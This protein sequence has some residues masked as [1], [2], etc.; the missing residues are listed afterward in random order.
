MVPVYPTREMLVLLP[1]QMVAEPDGV[2][3]TAS[4]ITVT[5]AT[6]ELS[7]GQ[8]PLLTIALKSEAPLQSD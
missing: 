2:P 4:G 8:T 5:V 7:F 3:A 1:V 6:E